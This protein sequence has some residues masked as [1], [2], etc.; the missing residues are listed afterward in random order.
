MGLRGTVGIVGQGY[1]G[2]PL[3]LAAA[4][5]Q[6]VV[7]G[8][9]NDLVRVS[10]IAA[11]KSPIE[12]ISDVEI[13]RMID[14]FGYKVTS[15]KSLLSSCDVVVICVPT[16]LDLKGDPDLGILKN[17]VSEVAPH[18]KPGALLI[19]E[20]TS[21]PGTVRSVIRPL[22]LEIR[23]R[24]DVEFACAPER[25]DPGN[26]EWSQSNTPR[27][28]AG[29]TESARARASNFYSTFCKEVVPVSSLEIAELAKLLENSFRQVNIALINDLSRLAQ[30]IGVDVW[31]VVDAAS[32]KPYGF[33]RFKPSIGVGG[34]CIP[35]DPIYLSE[36]AKVEGHSLELIERAQEINNSQPSWIV[37]RA[38]QLM[39]GDLRGRG[40][41]L[42][43][44]GYKRGTSDTRESPSVVLMKLLS[45]EG[46]EVSWQDEFIDEIDGV[47][48]GESSNAAELVIYCQIQS[49]FHPA[50][51]QSGVILD[52]TGTLVKSPK[53]IR[54]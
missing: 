17:A 44:M 29:L 19:N 45:R 53:V 50:N 40:I 28:V 21:F 2:L 47:R 11:G 52:C 32:T 12:D 33:M 51:F 8:F 49:D 41:H 10:Y 39:G 43:G 1:V 20:S 31:E 26:K 54:L 16:P 14:E 35:V 42:A 46:A 38:K 37:E 36:F 34:H 22:I 27:L 6:F 4:K 48:P 5:A 18:L 9:D 15:D 30:R 7:T 24:E 3:A 23:V 25:V 13:V